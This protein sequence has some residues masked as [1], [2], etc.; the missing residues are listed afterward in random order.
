MSNIGRF[1]T[2]L[3]K[4]GY[5][6][7]KEKNAEP[8]SS[9]F[10]AYRQGEVVYAGYHREQAYAASS[11]VERIKNPEHTAYFDALVKLEQ[12]ASIKWYADLR[13]EYSDLSDRVFSLVYSR[14]YDSC[15]SAGYDEVAA[16]MIS[17]HDYASQLISLIRSE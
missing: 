17:E 14:A 4:V 3:A 16:R 13:A 8:P 11:I 12:D 6:A 1:D 7:F 15:H 5:H 2:Y 9:I 10:Y